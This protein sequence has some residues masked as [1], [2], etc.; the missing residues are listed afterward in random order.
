[1]TTFVIVNEDGR[2]VGHM[3]LTNG[4]SYTRNLQHAQRYRRKDV[5]LCENERVVDVETLL[6]PVVEGDRR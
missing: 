2:F 6:G 3:H 4:K 5:V 1:M